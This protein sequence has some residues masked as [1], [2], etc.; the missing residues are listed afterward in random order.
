MCIRDRAEVDHLVPVATPNMRHVISVQYLPPSEGDAAPANYLASA[1][2]I[3][4]PSHAPEVEVAISPID[5]NPAVTPQPDPDCTDPDA[6]EPEVSTGPGQPADP[7]ADPGKPGDKVFRGEIVTTAR[8]SAKTSP[9]ETWMPFH[10][11]DGNAN[12]L[13]N[14]ALDDVC[15][16]PEYKVCAV[17][18]SRV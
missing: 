8:V 16:V 15:K 3:D 1:N 17:A 9:G 14:A 10:F 12:W 13:T 11:Q 6:P 4:D 2:P 18:V 7:G 5:P